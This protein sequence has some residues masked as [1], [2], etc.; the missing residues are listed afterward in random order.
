MASWEI[1]KR[2]FPQWDPFFA[3]VPINITS[4]VFLPSVSTSIILFGIV[5]G[6]S[7]CI[8]YLWLRNLSDKNERVIEISAIILL[9]GMLWIGIRL[10]IYII[11]FKW[12]TLHNADLIGIGFPKPQYYQLA[13]WIVG[14]ITI[15]CVWLFG[16]KELVKD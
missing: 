8:A 15:I 9:A 1:S 2:D 7:V 12:E 6:L 4:D 3:N 11:Q 16:K 14:T 10:V 5:A 13:I